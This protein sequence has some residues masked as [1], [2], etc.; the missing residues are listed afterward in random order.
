S[1]EVESARVVSSC[2]SPKLDLLA[3]EAV[4]KAARGRTRPYSGKRTLTRW[5]VE[6]AYAANPP[7]RMGFTFDETGLVRSKAQG[8]RKYVSVPEY[9]VGGHIQTRISLLAI[10]AD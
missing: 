1:G 4:E 3:K 9:L 5:A 7:N 10:R 6:S 8:I 2:G